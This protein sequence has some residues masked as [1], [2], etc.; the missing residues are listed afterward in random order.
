MNIIRYLLFLYIFSL[1]NNSRLICFPWIILSEYFS[2]NR[3]PSSLIYV[4]RQ[5]LLLWDFFDWIIILWARSWPT[6]KAFIR[7]CHIQKICLT[8]LSFEF[9]LFFFSPVFVSSPPLLLLPVISC[10]LTCSF[11]RNSSSSRSSLVSSWVAT[12]ERCE[13][14][15][16]PLRL[17]SKN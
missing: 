12:P 9:F 3:S 11:L 17:S 6:L 15:P 4:I 8:L 1:F 14:L 2:R 16:E 5:I 10:N 13:A 7:S